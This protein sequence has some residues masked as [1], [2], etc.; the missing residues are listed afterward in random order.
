M[1]FDQINNMNLKY[2]LA[3]WTL[4]LTDTM[5]EEFKNCSNLDGF[6]ELFVF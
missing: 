3:M 5:V 2:T 6:E 1:N 4:V